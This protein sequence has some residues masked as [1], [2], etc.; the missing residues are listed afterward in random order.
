MGFV[1]YFFL[2]VLTYTHCFHCSPLAREKRV[3]TRMSLLV[4]ATRAK[5]DN[6]RLK[7]LIAASKLFEHCDARKHDADIKAGAV[8]LVCAILRS[9]SMLFIAR[10]KEIQHCLKILLNLFRC[11]TDRLCASFCTDGT[12]LI[13]DL[14]EL[15]EINYRLGKKGDVKSLVLAQGVVDKLICGARVPLSKIKLQEDLF[16]SLVQNISGA[17]GSLVMHQSMKII[18]SLSENSQNKRA[19][20]SFP[21]MM[22]AIALGSTYMFETVRDE[23]ARIIMNLSLD[24]NNKRSLAQHYLDVVLAL[25][26]GTTTSKSYAIHTLGSLSSLPENKAIIVQHKNG[27]VVDVLLWVASSST[28]LIDLRIYATK[29]LGNL[30]VAQVGSHPRLLVS[31]SSLAISDKMNQLAVTAAMSVKKLSNHIRSSDPCHEALLQALVTMSYATSTGV[32]KWTVKA[33]CEQASSPSDRVS[34]I[35]HKGLLSSL[36]MLTNDDNEFVRENARDVLSAL[37]GKQDI[38]L[39]K[40]NHFHKTKS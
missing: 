10:S 28:Q 8:S 2:T 4:D 30:A 37:A 36:T 7:K 32:L 12:T 27:A 19:M 25:A 1:V 26:R 38:Y 13:I 33:Y 21:C 20:Y 35:G 23:S 40:C 24:T 5:T 9:C 3:I 22:D 6:D 31:L 11:S 29:I 18:A 17:T 39:L 14:L 16:S 34:M 15:I